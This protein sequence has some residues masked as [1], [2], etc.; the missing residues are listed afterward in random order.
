MRRTAVLLAK[1]RITEVFVGLANGLP[2]P[3][4]LRPT[5]P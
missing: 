1:R 4:L 3:P 5:G 2:L